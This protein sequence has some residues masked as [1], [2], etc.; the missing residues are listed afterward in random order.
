MIRLDGRICNDCGICLDVCPDY[1]FQKGEEADSHVSAAFPDNCCAC[2]HCISLCPV[3]ALSHDDLPKNE[4]QP[5]EKMTLDPDLLKNMLFRRRSIRSYTEEAVSREVIED[6]LNSATHACTGGNIQSEEYIVITDKT[7]LA[8]L[9][10]LVID[11][12]WNQGIKLFSGSGFLF[13]YLKKLYGDTLANQ[14]TT[15]HQII[16]QRRKENKLQ[17]MVFRDAPTLLIIHGLKKNN[18]AY[19]NA[20]IAIRNIELLALTHGLG[21]CWCGFLMSVASK[22]KKINEFLKLPQDRKIF[23]A[24]MLGY[25]KYKYK[26][27]IPRKKRSIQWI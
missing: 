3:A 23:G 4:F 21:S 9:E 12:L 8:E 26:K 2:G 16:S 1:V 14:Y 11:N 25:P 27:K 20:A 5:L 17:G 10:L 7:K 24:L 13:S 15:Y 19:S 22:S 6:L 18:M